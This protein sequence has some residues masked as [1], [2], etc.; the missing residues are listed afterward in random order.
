MSRKTSIDVPADIDAIL[1]AIGSPKFATLVWEL[2]R[3]HYHRETTGDLWVGTGPWRGWRL[4][5]AHSVSSYGQ[6]VLIGPDGVARGAGD[7]R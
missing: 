1:F 2:I 7:I 4:T 5:T 6:P 3:D